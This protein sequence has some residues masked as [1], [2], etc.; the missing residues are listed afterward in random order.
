MTF[1]VGPAMLLLEPLVVQV[2]GW[3]LTFEGVLLLLL[4]LLPPNLNNTKNLPS[5]FIDT[6]TPSLHI[7]MSG[8]T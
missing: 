3:L 6:Q 5:H 2:F 1:S 7:N 8:N 4:L